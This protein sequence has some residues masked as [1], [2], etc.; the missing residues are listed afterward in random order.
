M[1][2]RLWL[3]AKSR[4]LSEIIRRPL[5]T[6]QG[7]E[8]ALPEQKFSRLFF[9]ID[10]F[11]QFGAKSIFRG[12]VSAILKFAVRAYSIRVVSWHKVV[13]GS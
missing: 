7:H 3:L 12:E 10:V 9:L 1:A 6:T 4:K 11:F 5:H 13:L 8:W 2:L